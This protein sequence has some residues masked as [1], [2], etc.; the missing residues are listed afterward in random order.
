M[1]GIPQ[2]VLKPAKFG[3]FDKDSVLTY[4]DELNSKIEELEKELAD[5]EEAGSS[6]ESQLVQEY[7]RDL[8][9]AQRQAAEY[10]KAA[11]ASAA[12][13][14]DATEKA[15]KLAVALKAEQ[16]GRRADAQQMKQLLNQAQSQAK[17][18][19]DT[20]V[21]ELQQ[22][23]VALKGEI[24]TLTSENTKL[25]TSATA[26]GELSASVQQLKDDLTSSE[27]EMGDLK[28]QLEET[29]AALANM[30]GEMFA[31]D[32]QIEEYKTKAEDLEK[33]VAE[34]EDKVTELENSDSGFD[35]GFDMSALYAEAQ[36]NAQQLVK[37]A[38]MNADK[39]TREADEKAK[40]T[41]ADADAQAKKTVDD[42]NAQAKKTVDDANAKAK[43]TTEE[44]TAKAKKTVA[45]ADAQAKLTLDEAN[46]EAERILREAEE[47][48][49]S[50]NAEAETILSTART[51]AEAES[52]RIKKDSVE[53][54]RRVRQLTA[55]LHS[56]LTIEIDGFEK[57][58]KEAGE[59][60]ARA[61][62]T[63]NERIS[64]TN[65]IITEA[66]SSV[67]ETTKLENEK[68]DD[69]MAGNVPADAPIPQPAAKEEAPKSVK[70]SPAITDDFAESMMHDF[71]AMPDPE[72]NLRVPS[73]K[74]P[75]PMKK[76]AKVSSFNMSDLIK[77]A[78]A[79]VTE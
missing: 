21:K 38:K 15:T 56:M 48:M 29:T 47:R 58:M 62:K 39:T 6:Q 69:I 4:V 70:G 18:G 19:D 78:E 16:D 25:K 57:S 12:Q 66:R 1:D 51:E 24:S 3:G 40:K 76:P 26:S 71:A 46:A 45:E 61:A 11:Q 23:I 13:L 54:E 63:V 34:L 17:A 42:A 53:Q 75:T 77:D 73:D 37:T 2:N 31:K 22:E 14:K 5:R 32:S 44:A 72:N 79:A 27:K 9:A 67:E 28:S 20:K 8:E 52:V 60:M 64:E 59:L 7:K 30:E 65:A 33:K 10:Q 55:T 74:Q 68:M 36:K 41:V 50:A 49:S 35:P 43:T